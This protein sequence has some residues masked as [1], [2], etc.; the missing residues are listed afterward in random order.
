MKPLQHSHGRR[1]EGES[2]LS[3]AEL[4]AHAIAAADHRLVPTRDDAGLAAFAATV[5]RGQGLGV[6]AGAGGTDHDAR[7]TFRALG[8]LAAAFAS[9]AY[10]GEVTAEDVARAGK[11]VDQLRT[12]GGDVA[13]E[14]EAAPC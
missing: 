3:G 10:R 14:G 8:H 2:P 4:L 1:A 12:L 9:F 11:V 6:V 7:D 5:L 13:A